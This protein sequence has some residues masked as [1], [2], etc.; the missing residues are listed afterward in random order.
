LGNIFKKHTYVGVLFLSL[1][2]IVS[3]EKDFTDI[4]TGVISNTEFSTGEVVLEVEII[5]NNITSVRADNISLNTL[6]E[7]WLGVYNTPYAE[8]IEAGFVSQLSLPSDL[9]VS[10][11]SIN[12]TTTVYSL[13]KVI[14]KIP[15]TSVFVS[16]EADGKSKFRLDSILGNPSIPTELEV[17]RNG[18]FINRLDPADPSKE[19]S[20]SSDFVY[21]EEELLT[22]A[23]FTFKPSAVDTVFYF[24]RADRSIALN[25]TT[26]IQDTLKLSTASSLAA[27]FLAIPLDLDEMK[28]LF[29]DKFEDPDFS[30]SAEFQTYFKGIILKTKGADG[31]LVPINLASE[32]TPSIDFFYAK[33][34][35]K[36]SDVIA[37]TT[38]T[39]SFPLSNAR[40]STYTM[41]PASM[42]VPNENFIIQGTAGASATV[43]ILGVNL[44]ELENSNPLDPILEYKDKDVNNDGFLDLEELASL[45]DEINQEGLL[46]NDALLTFYVN[47]V[48][49]PD[50]DILPQK[51]LIYK[52]IEMNGRVTPTHIE[53]SYTEFASFGGGLLLDEDGT[54]ER[55]N[56]KVTDYISNLLDGTNDD[57]PTL[58]LKVFN[59]ATDLPVNGSGALDVSVKTYNW[60]P[61]AVLLLNG[62]NT[63]N[64][65]KKAQ[66]KISY[67][68]KKK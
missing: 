18:T 61:R 40:S 65:V 45:T 21:Q 12:D 66:L 67:T 15:Y 28:R 59:K 6:E 54:P 30:S 13:D 52:N 43:K 42:S 5:Q 22:A 25:S 34:I 49:S 14:L 51:L 35:L 10:E 31:A 53:D 23:G 46:V 33:T 60:N 2:G 39:Y 26:S 58:E 56:F 29:W 11:A 16:K 32:S 68:E 19:N 8:K 36:G 64:G 20:F 24:N 4:G 1:A 57:L 62:D 55:Y 41:S 48:A 17:Y 44:L 47:T 9:V 38:S 3:C 50:A 7:Y 37:N 63:T 27:P